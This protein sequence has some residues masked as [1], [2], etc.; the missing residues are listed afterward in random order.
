[1][2]L[3]PK[4]EKFAQLFIETGCMS[5]AYRGA[6]NTSRMKPNTVNNRAKD[7]HDSPAV[8][9][10]IAELQGEHR[11]RHD[12]TVDFVVGV[13]V[14]TIERCRQV[15]PV[16]DKKGEQVYVEDA[17]GQQVP[18]FKFDAGN[19]LRGAEL[20]GK[21]LGMFTDKIEHSGAV[22]QDVVNLTPEQVIEYMGKL[23]DEY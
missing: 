16:L 8:A 4:Q 21:H 14:E 23:D 20:L 11:Q 18:A 12:V 3:K 10:R 15:E 17:N 13:V 2:A 1:M 5:T 22:R 6:Y 9:A 7:L 19:V